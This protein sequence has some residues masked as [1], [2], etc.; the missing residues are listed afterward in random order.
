LVVAR[1][2]T[3]VAAACVTPATLATLKHGFDEAERPRAIAV[4]TASFGVGAALGPVLAGVLLAR[5]GV[6]AVLLANLPPVALCFWGSWRLV[7]PDLPR[8]D[9][10]LDW[11]G[12]ALCLACAGCWL[13]AILAG[14]SQG[15]LAPQVALSAL[16][17][18]LCAGTA[19][20][21]LKRARHPLFDLRLFRQRR[22]SR[23]LLVILLGYFAFSGVAFVVAQYLQV[24]RAKPAFDAGLLSLPLASS[25]LIGTL[26]APR[27]MSY[28]GTERALSVSLGC[29]LL[30]ATLLAIASYGH[31]DLFLGV[32][33][34]PF[35]LGCGSTFA[36]ATELTLG[37]VPVERAATAGAVSESAFEFG[38]VLGV[39]VLSTLLGT[40][41]VSAESVANHAPR[42]LWVGAL[43]VLASL[44][45]AVSLPARARPHLPRAEA[46]PS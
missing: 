46:H 36:N 21:W 38:G 33:L 40:S 8:R 30:G 13:F 1:A 24:A 5:G 41:A 15:W 10:P 31:D 2:A 35:G 14:P 6:P 12:L 23:A 45:V 39:A 17:G 22:F 19:L 29:A 34:L 26:L 32:T 20:V 42:A 7:S 28:F 44:L 25:L 11:T 16:A 3:G 27:M 37:S 18:G 4:W 43:A 9:V